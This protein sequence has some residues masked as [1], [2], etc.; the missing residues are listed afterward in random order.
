MHICLN[1]I[2][3]I[4]PCVFR[5]GLTR[6]GHVLLLCLLS[7]CR[8][9]NGIHQCKQR[10]TDPTTRR[11]VPSVTS[12]HMLQKITFLVSLRDSTPSFTSIVPS[13]LFHF[14]LALSPLPLS[15]MVRRRLG[16]FQQPWL[17]HVHPSHGPLACTLHGQQGTVH[18]PS[19]GTEAAHR[20]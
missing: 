4:Q 5:K 1:T 14:S 2:H 13:P 15:V 12:G 9:A 16:R 3:C 18:S 20:G 8:T 6:Q 19:Q 11:P 17:S 10:S 7:V